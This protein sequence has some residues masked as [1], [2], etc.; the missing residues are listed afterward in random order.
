MQK[1]YIV[2]QGEYSDYRICGVFDDKDL[3]GKFITSFNSPS[4]HDVMMIEEWN[5]NP[6]APELKEGHKP[7]F[8]RMKK[9]GDTIEIELR[10]APYGFDGGATTEKFD[11]LK[12]I[13]VYCFAKDKQHAVKITNE[14]RVQLIALNKWPD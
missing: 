8:V 3:A 5:L 13:Q 4:Y 9:N 12:N 11:M 6:Y 2:T 1:I 10:D 14:R 7:F